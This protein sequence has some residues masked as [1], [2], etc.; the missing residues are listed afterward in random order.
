MKTSNLHGG[1]RY[2][3]EIISPVVWLYFR[4]SLSLNDIE[5]LTASRGFFVTFETIRQ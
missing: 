4:F 3:A 5:E 1:F 2:P